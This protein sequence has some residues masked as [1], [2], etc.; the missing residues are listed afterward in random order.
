VSSL[1]LN[2]VRFVYEYFWWSDLA[3][4]A[5]SSI[6]S[7]GCSFFDCCFGWLFGESFLHALSQTITFQEFCGA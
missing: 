2:D 5:C 7:G 3:L 4:L 1:L 6:S